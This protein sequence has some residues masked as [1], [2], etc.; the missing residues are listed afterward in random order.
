MLWSLNSVH[1]PLNLATKKWLFHL[2][3]LLVVIQTKQD[4][5]IELVPKTRCLIL[6]ILNNH[7]HFQTLNAFLQSNRPSSFRSIIIITRLQQLPGITILLK[8]LFSKSTLGV[9]QWGDN[10]LLHLLN[11][12]NLNSITITQMESQWCL[13]LQWEWVSNQLPLKDR[14]TQW[15]IWISN[16]ILRRPL[17]VV[18]CRIT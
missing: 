15:V 18:G 7:P 17:Q 6:L 10:I 12:W 3:R 4:H 9:V 13:E 11:N 14:E 1:R 16:I 8:N 5:S 2:Q